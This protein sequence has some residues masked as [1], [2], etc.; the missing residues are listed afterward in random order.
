MWNNKIKILAAITCLFFATKCADGNDQKVHTQTIN[1]SFASS[2][3]KFVRKKRRSMLFGIDYLGGAK[4][5]QLILDEHPNGWAAGF[6]IEDD[7]FGSPKEVIRKL[8]KSGRAPVIR[9][10]LAWKDDHQF[11]ESDFQNIVEYAKEYAEFPKRYKNV[12][13]YFSGATEHLLNREQAER[14]AKKILAVLPKTDN[15]IYVNNPWENRGAFVYG[16]RIINEVH[17]S[18]AKAPRGK[19]IFSYDGSSAVDD[20]VMLRKR[21]MKNSEVFFFW[22]PAMNGRLKVDDETPRPQRRSWPTSALIDSIIYLKNDAGSGIWIP[23][24][25]LWKS[26]ADRHRTP[27]ESRAYKPVLIS[28]IKVDRFELITKNGR[29]VASSGPPMQF[30]DGRWRYYFDDFGHNIAEKAIRIQKDPVCGLRAN[31]K[32]YGKVNPAFRAGSFRK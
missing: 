4:Y 5:Q 29:V 14:L 22:H 26:H 8:A 28:P 10:N 31:G 13:W 7:L 21:V 2:E 30:E 32:V 15:C 25:W 27:P 12:T 17:G 3:A 19:F 9:I 11:I 16:R 23:N 18:Y 24:N 20:D 6:F 1:Q